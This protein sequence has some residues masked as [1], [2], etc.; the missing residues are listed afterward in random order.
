MITEPRARPTSASCCPRRVPRGRARAHARARRRCCVLD[1]TAH[2]DR[3]LRRADAR[4][5][6]STPDVDHARQEPR[7]RRPDR[8]VRD[9]RRPARLAGAPPRRATAACAGPRHRRHDVRQP[10]LARR[11]GRGAAPHPDAGGLDAPPRSG[12][13]S[14]T[15][16]RPRPR[17][18][19]CPGARTG[20][21]A[22]PG[23]C[24]EPEL[25]RD[26]RV[27]RRRSTSTR[28]LD[29]HAACRH[30]A[31]RGVWDGDRERRVPAASFAPRG[32]R[33]RRS[34]CGALRRAVLERHVGA[35]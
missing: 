6:R 35:G 10:A 21:A 12:R 29:R 11:R 13:S 23:Y 33:R 15:A 5:G 30:M 25:P 18:T 3:R 7:R 1:E 28:E 22:A 19:A 26:A 14:P 20:S 27:R 17:A 34:T 2:A 9:D 4:L 31:N 8:R 16:S 24:L 32:R